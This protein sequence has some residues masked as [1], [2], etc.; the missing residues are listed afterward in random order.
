ML[1]DVRLCPEGGEELV[2][3][4]AVGHEAKHGLVFRRAIPTLE[5]CRGLIRDLCGER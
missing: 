2:C 3:L 1:P 5:P 4:S